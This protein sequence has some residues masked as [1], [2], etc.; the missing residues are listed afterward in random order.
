MADTYRRIKLNE[1]H[2]K[3]TEE[4]VNNSKIFENSHRKLEANQVGFLGE[5]VLEQFFTNEKIKF[6]NQTHETTH[7]YLIK[8]KYTLDLKT[9][10]RRQKKY[11]HQLVSNFFNSMGRKSLDRQQ[12]YWKNTRKRCAAHSKRTYS[13]SAIQRNN[14]TGKVTV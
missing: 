5:I 4:R 3:L 6:V 13:Q 9:K 7:D 2:W 8:Q 10:D 11:N 14:T 12:I 1:H